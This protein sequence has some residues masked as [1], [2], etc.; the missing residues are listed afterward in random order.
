[1][2]TSNIRLE[3][4]D[5]SLLLI[6][7]PIS[8][9]PGYVSLLF[10]TIILVA[11]VEQLQSV[12][13]PTEINPVTCSQTVLGYSIS[14]CPGVIPIAGPQLV[15]GIRHLVRSLVAQTIVPFP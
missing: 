6:V 11:A 7:S 2:G 5:G 1:M 3:L 8:F 13:L 12:A 4:K 14:Q 15:K 9:S 10:P